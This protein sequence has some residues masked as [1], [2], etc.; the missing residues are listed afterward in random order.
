MTHLWEVD[1]PYY[2]NEGCFFYSSVDT[3]SYRVHTNIGSWSEFMALGWGNSDLDMNLV[4]RWDWDKADPDDYE[5]EI[6]H[7]PSFEL[8]GDVL[9]IFFFLQR[10][11]YPHSVFVDVTEADEADV[12]E[13]LTVRAQHMRKLWAP[14]LDG[15][16]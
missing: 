13:W 9:K 2:C 16:S 11:A 8:P 15:A 4:F 12:R 10:K 6:E 1:H 7:D 3:G 14:L 5:Y